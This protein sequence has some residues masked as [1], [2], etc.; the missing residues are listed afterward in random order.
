MNRRHVLKELSGYLDNQLPEPRKKEVEAHLQAC[1][2]CGA[3][4]S[5][6]RLLSEKLKLWQAPSLDSAFERSVAGE[7][8]RGELERGE[9]KMKRKTLT[10]L[11]PSGVLAGILVFLFMGQVY[12]KRSLQG[13]IGS[14]SDVAGEEYA[15]VSK[16]EP[17]YHDYLGITLEDGKKKIKGAESK[18]DIEHSTVYYSG[19]GGL[20][21]KEMRANSAAYNQLSYAAE[22][23]DRHALAK[24]APARNGY[25]R[26]AARRVDPSSAPEAGKTAA[27]FGEG[28]VIVIQPVLPATGEG[29]KIIRIAQVRLEVEDGKAAYKKTSEICQEL[30]GYLA[31]SNFYKDA[32]GRE[33]GVITMRIPK[34]KFLTA[35]ERLSAL[36]KVEKS[37]TNSHD[38]S[39]EYRNLKARL[40][41]AMVVYNK[42]LEAL[43]KRQ[44]NIPEAVRLESELTPVLE[45]IEGL[46]NQI[47]Y[48][49]NAISF[50]TITID[51]YEPEVSLKVLKEAKRDIQKSM[52]AATIKT[53]KLLANAMPAAIAAT[54]WLMIG[55]GLVLAIKYWFV[56]LFKRG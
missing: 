12:F 23:M 56:R 14:M 31:H 24:Q 8:V 35:L 7:I 21:H 25:V 4:L 32:E 5:R 53:V 16:Y 19:V 13:R 50:T 2:L 39:Q 10:I 48:L 52:L 43:Q 20:A 42:M 37:L 45:R 36:G 51:F 46:K 41:A 47:E 11:I 30:G 55:L 54:V 28:S 3:E 40:D 15:P 34:D 22:A 9:V 27:F 49:D 44:T 6:L 29:E 33:T 1:K 26:E 17:H 38:V 18:G